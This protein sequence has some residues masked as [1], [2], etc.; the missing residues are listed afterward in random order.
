M[1]FIFELV[2]VCLGGRVCVL[3]KW[4]A[5]SR[6]DFEEEIERQLIYSGPLGDISRFSGGA[7]VACGVGPHPRMAAPVHRCQKK[8]PRCARR[9][10]NGFLC[11]GAGLQS[12]HEMEDLSQIAQSLRVRPAI[13]LTRRR[14][15][16]A[17]A[18]LGH[19]GGS[20][21]CNSTPVKCIDKEAI[22]YA[23][24]SFLLSRQNCVIHIRY[25]I[26]WTADAS[27]VQ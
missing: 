20:E 11:R 8:S 2:C 26:C 13:W 3:E 17:D 5:L 23:H 16:W 9:A 14:R 4:V 7:Q 10:R 1:L 24:D 21:W 6:L 15:A 25:H 19:Q 18:A 12:I 22:N 27:V